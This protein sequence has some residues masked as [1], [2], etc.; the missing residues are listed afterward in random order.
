MSV[1]RRDFLKLAGAALATPAL[2]RSSRAAETVSLYDLERFGNVRI[3]HLTDTHAQLRPVYFREP[4]VNIGIGAMWG[5]P[6]HLVERAFLDRYGIRPDS[7]EAYAFTSF[8]FEKSAPRFGRLG[9][10]AHLKTLVDK[11]RGDVGEHRSLLVDGGDL[12]QGSGLANT[13][14]GT[15]MVEAANLLGIEAMTGHWEFTYGEAALRDNLA[16]FK[17]EFLAQNVFLTEEAA[18]ND[19]KA[20]DPV[21]RRVFKPA[22]IKEIGG[23]RIAVIGQAFPYVPIAHPKRFTPDWTFGIHEEELQALVGELRKEKAD[24]VVLLSHNGM[25]VD[26]KLASRVTGIDVILGG[27][28]H[29]AVPQ[30]VVVK[31]ANGTT[32]VTNAGSNG[33]FLAVLDLEIAK[34]HIA[35]VRYRLLPVYSELLKPD[36]AMQALIDQLQQPQVAVWSDKVATA[37]RLLYRRGN[38]EGSTDELICDALRN[39]LDAEIAFSPGFRWG[40]TMLAGQSVTIEDLLAQTAITYPETYVQEMTGSEIKDVLE[41]VCDNLFNADP[42]LQQGGDMVRVGGLTYRCAPSEAIGRRISDL[43]RTGGQ[44]LEANRRYKVAGWA[45]MNAQ[46]GKPVWEVVASHLRSAAP[47]ISAHSVVLSGVDGNPGLADPS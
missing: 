39:E 43:K 16:R 2:L 12:W 33:K 3:L 20:F 37:E 26:L 21:S 29:D 27:H 46:T 13:M 38:F 9:G 47:S 25:D 24:A 5:Q 4:S 7:A 32:L 11:L 6:P 17:G 34:G 14:Q 40:P 35:D 10:F 42:Y 31:N 41:D 23:F 18:F 30:P 22:T 45:S 44:A 15:D 28:T 36:P 19:A 8:E 1:R